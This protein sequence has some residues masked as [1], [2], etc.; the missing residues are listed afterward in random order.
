MV[1]GPENTS[2][3]GSEPIWGGHPSGGQFYHINPT[4]MFIKEEEFVAMNRDASLSNRN[5]F[6]RVLMLNQ[7]EKAG[8][9]FLF[10]S[11]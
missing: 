11:K 9:N 6:Y 4:L 3:K 5:T 2:R 7:K 10:V 8:N 1:L